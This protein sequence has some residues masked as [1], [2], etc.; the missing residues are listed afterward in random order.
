M[1]K[2]VEKKY[3]KT[4]PFLKAVSEN[5]KKMVHMESSHSVHHEKRS[6]DDMQKILEIKK[7]VTEIMRNPF[8]ATLRT[9]KL[10]N[11][12]TGETLASTQLVNAKTIGLKAISDAS[13]TND[14]II[15]TQKLTTFASQQ[16]QSKGKRD[17]MKKLINEENTVKKALCFKQELSDKAK[18][19]AFSY[20]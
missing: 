8:A 1:Q 19:E 7:T 14:V 2:L 16:K 11:I 10:V 4:L 20:K 6:K 3:I 18:I 5:V 13:T 15:V 17:C 12:A 9:D